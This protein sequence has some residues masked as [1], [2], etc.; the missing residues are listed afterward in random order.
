MLDLPACLTTDEDLCTSLYT[1]VDIAQDYLI[2]AEAVS[3]LRLII[4]PGLFTRDTHA[5]LVKRAS[6][7]R[8]NCTAP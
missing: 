5:R 2:T 6:R 8:A 4:E 1:E 3:K 7:H